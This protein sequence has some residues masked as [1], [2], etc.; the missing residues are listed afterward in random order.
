LV[1][2]FL[3]VVYIFNHNLLRKLRG[4]KIMTDLAEQV[5]AEIAQVQPFS[6]NMPL[7]RDLTRWLQPVDGIL[8]PLTTTLQ[9]F[10]LHLEE[11]LDTRAQG[12]STSSS[13]DTSTNPLENAFFAN[14]LRMSTERYVQSHGIVSQLLTHV[15]TAFNTDTPGSSH[16]E[17]TLIALA[18]LAN[19]PE[20]LRAFGDA[21]K[22]LL[23]TKA[24]R[25]Y[26]DDIGGH[27]R[28]LHRVVNKTHAV[29]KHAGIM[30][31]TK[32]AIGQLATT[33][34]ATGFQCAATH[35]GSPLRWRGGSGA[36]FR[37]RVTFA[38]L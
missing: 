30:P 13:I 38:P 37:S 14:Q 12:F 32:E 22:S 35:R 5:K 23:T 19:N 6:L 27:L 21:Q 25:E 11:G 24:L 34:V 8:S 9:D 15:E 10:R 33:L 2:T 1:F 31:C 36:A 3:F 29:I 16:P 17:P 26:R 7:A 28:C 20:P 4:I 18:V